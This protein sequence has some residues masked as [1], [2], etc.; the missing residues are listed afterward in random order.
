MFLAKKGHPSTVLEMRDMLAAD[1]TPI[2]YYNMVRDAWEATEGFSSILKAKV[3]GITDAGVTYTDENGES[4]IVEADTVIL[5]VGTRSKRDEAYA[6][7]A[8]GAETTVIGDALAVKTVQG[9]MRTGYA[10]G[11]NA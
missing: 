9:A 3:T 4:K 5:S 10:A 8:P 2:H 7:Y 6:F 1:A 11:N